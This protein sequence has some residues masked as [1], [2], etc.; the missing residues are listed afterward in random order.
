MAAK[1]E[2]SPE[3]RNQWERYLKLHDDPRLTP[4]GRFLRRTSIDELPQ[5]INVIRGDMSLIGPRP[6]LPG[7]VGRYG[8]WF[9]LYMS[10]RPGLTGLWQISGRSLSS[11]RRRIAAD[12]IYVRRRSV[13]LKI[14]ILLATIP[15]V[16]SQKG[17]A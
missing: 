13:L 5:L 10:V 17:S 15:S 14:F 3:A 6:I 4:I 2:F 7:E 11:F 9:A 1:L 8:R 16:L 12:V